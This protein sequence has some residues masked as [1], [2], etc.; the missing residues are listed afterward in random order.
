MLKMTSLFLAIAILL[1]L[2]FAAWPTHSYISYTHHTHQKSW[3]PKSA[4]TSF[5]I[6]NNRQHHICISRLTSQEDDIHNR[7]TE[8]EYDTSFAEQ[9]AV[10]GDTTYPTS[11]AIQ[12][13]PQS[14]TTTEVS[15]RKALL[16][17]LSLSIISTAIIPDISSASEIDT[18]GELFSPKN[19]MIK[20]GGSV[21]ARGI[22]LNPME[23]KAESRESRNKSLLSSTGLIQNV[24]ETRFITYM[25]RFLL[26]IDPAASAWW[27]KNSRPSIVATDE[28]GNDVLTD[29][30]SKE[31]FAEFAE[32]V[33]IG[34]ADY[35]LG[36]YGSY[37]SVAAAK[38]GVS[39]T[40]PA[41]SVR[42]TDKGTSLWSILTGGKEMQNTN[43]N[44]AINSVI[45]KRKSRKS[46]REETK[47]AK[48]GVLNLFSLLTARYTSIEE[49]KQLAILFSLISKPELQPV[50]EIRGLLGEIDNGTIAEIEL[51]DLSDSNDF[52]LS[53]RTGGGFSKDGDE[54]IRVDPPPPLGAGYTPAKIRAVTKPTTRILRINVVDGGEGYT[55]SPDVIIKQRGV[56]RQ[57]D[58][59]AIT[60][61]N[62]SVSE[63][64]VLDP[65]YGYGGQQA[66]K[67]LDP[68]L[69]T[70]EIRER[71]SLR[72]K[73]SKTKL[74]R[75][76]KAVAELE[77]KVCVC[78]ICS[79]TITC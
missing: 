68:S 77:Y 45:A 15:R 3:E 50:Q 73:D 64:I 11:Y 28:N 23:K 76:A 17:L 18:T 65:G 42:E 71:K 26:S 52:R 30:I 63:I 20:G 78:L 60:D 13:L 8:I 59:C 27:E 58:A 62:G 6:H 16:Q 47:L 39:A 44:N 34:L 75:T 69:P 79:F 37:A 74:A 70:V 7:A 56:S 31:L 35:F 22:R 46:E 51:V 38:A 10:S 9:Y 33:E 19:E 54:I 67:G 2:I 61:R 40:A 43:T 14:T 25:A 41:K 36:P 29:N 57:C 48:Q 66:G 32:S 4:L 55:I 53:S 12:R 5:R 21:A 72:R 1:P 49:K 24:Y